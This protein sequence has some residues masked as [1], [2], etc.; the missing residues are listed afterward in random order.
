[1]SKTTLIFVRHGYSEGNEK[2]IFTGWYNVGLNEQGK[3]Q[4]KLT[5]EYLKDFDIDRLYCSDL[6]RAVETAQEICK[7]KNLKIE[8]DSNLREINGG[9]WENKPFD[10][11]IKLYPKEYKVWLDDIGRAHCVNGESVKELQK[12][13]ACAV[14]SI[15]KENSGKTVCIVTHA[16][17]IRVL[18]TYWLG[19]KIEYASEI[20]YVPNSS[21][22]I[23]KYDGDKASIKVNGFAGHMGD[24]KTNLPV[25]V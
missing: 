18:T 7:I 2:K 10:D 17:P 12:R 20:P 24:L 3:K 1:M 25:S 5:A 8:T 22:T 13:V 15:V 9:D 16:T 23:V 19:K 14:E 4:A 6:K 21:I 11:L